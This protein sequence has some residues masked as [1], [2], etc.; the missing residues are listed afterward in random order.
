MER[1]FN[2]QKMIK[3]VLLLAFLF[4][5]AI[6]NLNGQ[7]PKK[8]VMVGGVL[9]IP[10]HYQTQEQKTFYFNPTVGYFLIDNLALGLSLESELHIDDD[11]HTFSF[12]AGPMIRYYLG[13]NRVKTFGHVSYLASVV[14]GNY[15]SPN[16]FISHLN[17]GIGFCY[18]LRPTVGIEALLSYN[19]YYSNIN[20]SQK[21]SHSSI[22]IGF[23]IYIPPI[24]NDKSN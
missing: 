13:K 16:E 12:G 9:D 22:H 8:T 11:N 5:I 6:F 19:S 3:K 1:T 24:L 15:F 4:L 7:I 18:L 23:Q 20:I 17:S 10:L 14:T 2:N 21:K